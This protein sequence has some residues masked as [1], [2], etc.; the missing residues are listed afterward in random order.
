MKISRDKAF[1]RLCKLQK[2]KISGRL[3][4]IRKRHWESTKLSMVKI[5]KDGKEWNVKSA[6]GR[7]EYDA[8]AKLYVFTCTH[9]YTCMDYL[10]AYPPD[11]F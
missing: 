7:Q 3:T 6:D 11:L 1:D 4:T 10:Q 9:V 2:G 8:C 5:S